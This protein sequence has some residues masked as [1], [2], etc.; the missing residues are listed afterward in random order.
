MEVL[1][2]GLNLFKVQSVFELEFLLN[3]IIQNPRRKGSWA[4]KDVCLF[5]IYP[6]TCQIWK[7]L[8]LSKRVICIFETRT[9][10]FIG[11]EV[12][13]R[14]SVNG[15]TPFTVR[16]SPVSDRPKTP[17]I[18]PGPTRP[19]AA[20]LSH[21]LTEPGWEADRVALLSSPPSQDWPCRLQTLSNAHHSHHHGHGP[22]SSLSITAHGLASKACSLSP[23]RYFPTSASPA[24]L[25]TA[26]R[27]VVP[28]LAKRCRRW[29][30]KP[31]ATGAVASSE[32]APSSCCRVSKHQ[33]AKPSSAFF[34]HV[35]SSP[36]ATIRRPSTSMTSAPAPRCSPTQSSGASTPHLSQHSRF[37]IGGFFRGHLTVDSHL[38]TFPSP[39][40]TA[41][42]SASTSCTSSTTSQ[43]P[44]INGPTPHQRCPP[45]DRW[46]Q[47]KSY[48]G[49]LL[50]R[51]APQINSPR[52]PI[53]LATA[54]APPRR[55]VLPDLAGATA[56][57]R[58]EQA[59]LF[60]LVGCQP[61]SWPTLNRGRLEDMVGL[62]QMHSNSSQFLIDL[63]WIIQIYPNRPKF[64][65]NSNKFGKYEINSVIWI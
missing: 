16:P 46:R 11:K 65:G 52:R 41:K 44:A 47:R 25:C 26:H 4:K 49:E 19:P 13:K 28:L 57:H 14:N 58:G 38:W 15:L 3:F 54:P 1:P 18:G 63:I 32:H 10:E 7:F 36:T 6:S 50:T 24:M 51:L 37:P 61:K 42:T 33:S 27:G 20:C 62:A 40:T 30:T 56:G 29:A 17:P 35:D 39:A 59:H 60:P 55:R 43:V 21:V 48:L 8:E 45:F 12:N 23:P 64:I 5:W 53:A 34:L 2:K 31:S 9:L 22:A